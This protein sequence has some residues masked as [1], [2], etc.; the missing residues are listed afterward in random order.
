MHA[1]KGVVSSLAPK[2]R[3]FGYKLILSI[4]LWVIYNNE[5]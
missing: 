3:Y 2:D 1:K 5:D 4:Y